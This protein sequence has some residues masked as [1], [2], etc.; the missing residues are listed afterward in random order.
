MASIMVALLAL[1]V[2]GFCAGGKVRPERHLSP[3]MRDG[4][5]AD[6][7]SNQ[8]IHLLTTQTNSHLKLYRFNPGNMTEQS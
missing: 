1:L 5:V 4:I 6:M 8:T 2:S 7:V 3:T